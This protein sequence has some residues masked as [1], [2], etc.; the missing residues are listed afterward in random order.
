M[1]VPAP[2]DPAT[3]NESERSVENKK[4]KKKE[5]NE[6]STNNP[7]R[8]ISGGVLSEYIRE[9]FSNRSKHSQ[10]EEFEST[11]KSE[12]LRTEAEADFSKETKRSP[13]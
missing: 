8:T 6:A 7:R 4:E 11:V 12:S 3:F 5:G 9:L 13:V 1:A 2:I 10:S